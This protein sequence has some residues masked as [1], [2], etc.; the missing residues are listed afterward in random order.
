MF[1]KRIIILFIVFILP[2]CG[3]GQFLDAENKNIGFEANYGYGFMLSHELTE[4]KLVYHTGG[5]PGYS[6]IIMQF[7]ESGET[8]IVL[9]NNEYEQFLQLADNIMSILIYR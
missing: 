7:I 1:N 9:S 5:W 6:T 4:N 8:V 2:F 3:Y